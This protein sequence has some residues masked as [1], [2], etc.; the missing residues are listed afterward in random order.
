M[1]SWCDA[2]WLNRK[3]FLFP[4]LT[5]VIKQVVLNYVPARKNVN[6]GHGKA[7]GTH[8]GPNTD[9]A[10]RLPRPATLLSGMSLP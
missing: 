5:A 9:S 4:L 7:P 8:T 2:L 3:N 10:G 1:V 6:A